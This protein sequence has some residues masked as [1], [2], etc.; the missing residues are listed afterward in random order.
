MGMAEAYLLVVHLYHKMRCVA[1]V[2][3]PSKEQ[4]K[5]V[6]RQ[7]DL[8]SNGKLDREEF[9]N[10]AI[11]LCENVALRV[12]AEMAAKFTLVPFVTSFILRSFD[13]LKLNTRLPQARTW[14]R[15]PWRDLVVLCVSSWLVPALLKSAD[16]TALRWS[17]QA[18]SC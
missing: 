15:V 3:L 5:L 11:I 9:K 14:Q 10:L 8:D 12:A 6:V 4:I 13:L 1:N 16:V 2:T 17:S 18:I 7:S